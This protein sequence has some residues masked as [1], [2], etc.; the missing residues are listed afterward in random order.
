GGF[1]STNFNYYPNPVKDVFSFSYS[2]VI[3]DVKVF[4]LLGQQVIDFKIDATQGQIDVSGLSNGAYLVRF[5]SDNQV[6][7]IKII[8]N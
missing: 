1:D 6:K 2:N 4:N 7:T 8:K 5:T 3:S